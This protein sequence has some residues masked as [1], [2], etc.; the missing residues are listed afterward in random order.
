MAFSR[1]DFLKLGGVTAV[2]LS[3]AACSTAGRQL[4]LREIPESLE[5]AVFTSPNLLWRL[6]NR[7]GYGPR[8][9][10]YQRASEIGFAAYLEQQ[11]NPEAIED[12]A[13]ELMARN[14]TLYSMDIGQLLAQDET[15]AARELISVAVTRPLYSQKQLYESMVEFWSDHFN[16]YL[17]KTEMMPFLKIIDDRDHIRP[18]VL[19]K[20]RDLLGASVHS[21][22]ML[23]Y[24]D[25]VRNQKDAPNENYARELMELHTLGVN[26]GYDQHDVQELA[27]IL[28]GWTVRRRGLRQGAVFFDEAAHDFGEKQLLG[29]TFPAGR[30]QEEIE[31]ALDL[32]A[33]HPS[34]AVFIAA[35]LVRRFVVDEPPA[36]LVEQV[37]RTFGETE[38]NIKATLRTLFL[39]DEFASAPPKLKRPFT[40]MISALRALNTNLRPNRGNGSWLEWLGQPPLRWAT[41]DGYPDTADAWASNLLPRWNFALSLVHGQVPGANPAWNRLV[42]AGNVTDAASGL[43]LLA[44]LLWGR[45]LPP[46]T[47]SLFTNYIGPG[48]LNDSKTQLRLKDA[49]A[50]LIASPA[51]QWT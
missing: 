39:S 19:G 40:F 24:L 32:L 5:T 42:E 51:F 29:Q 1:R 28:T 12:T 30:G 23:V 10:D 41:P 26:G 21:P 3:T 27:R 2:T 47:Q 50:L 49:A 4:A 15:D 7:A 45:P 33:A 17:R 48:Q 8:P 35:K 44:G 14:L 11:L 20:F 22:A 9:G 36:S 37:A 46:E 16:I 18:H 31:A 38:G 13:V 43:D 34:T 6:L 25:N